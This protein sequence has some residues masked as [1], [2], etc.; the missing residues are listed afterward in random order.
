[1]VVRKANLKKV[2][3]K[4]AIAFLVRPVA[5]LA[6]QSCLSHFLALIRTEWAEI[7]VGQDPGG[8]GRDLVD[9]YLMGRDS[10]DIRLVAGLSE[11]W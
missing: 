9:R 8:V 5:F 1:L 6:E 11:E 3:L 2:S 10:A 7:Q 4:K